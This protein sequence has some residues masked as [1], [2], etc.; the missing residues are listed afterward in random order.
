MS[1][2]NKPRKY[3]FWIALVPTMLFIVAISTE[4]SVI[5]STG[6]I[7]YLRLKF[8][9]AALVLVLVY[10]LV[11]AKSRVKNFSLD[12]DRLIVYR[13]SIYRLS[14]QEI[15][16]RHIKDTQVQQIKFQSLFN[17]ASLK[18]K[19]DIEDRCVHSGLTNSKSVNLDLSKVLPYSDVTFIHGLSLE[20]AERLEGQLRQKMLGHFDVNAYREPID[21]ESARR[22]NWSLIIIAVLPII[23]VT[24][25]ALFI[26]SQ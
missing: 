10:R 20:Q 7:E 5:N 22:T 21:W 24:V 17:L 13:Q 14:R 4:F 12:Q 16:Y 19:T 26:I 6:D 25:Y 18:I 3:Y 9:G 23:F 11:V 15:P 8:F 1:E 2:F